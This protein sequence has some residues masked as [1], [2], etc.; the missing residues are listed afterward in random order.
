[1]PEECKNVERTA[2]E[3]LTACME[4]QFENDPKAQAKEART[5]GLAAKATTAA[6]ISK[7]TL[8][9]EIIRCAWF[10]HRTAF[11]FW[12]SCDFVE[13]LPHGGKCS[14]G[15]RDSGK[16]DTGLVEVTLHA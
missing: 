6:S 9:P 16:F 4:T 8:V 1:M 2:V 15:I 12:N 3:D 5:Q 7:L 11:I 14:V 13:L 10:L